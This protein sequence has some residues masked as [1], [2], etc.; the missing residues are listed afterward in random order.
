MTMIRFNQHLPLTDLFENLFGNTTR[1][2]MHSHEYD[3]EPLAN[4]L[5]KNN[6]FELQMA[7]PGVKKE[8]VKISLEKNVLSITSEKETEKADESVKYTRRE[9][10]YGTFCRSFT[11]PETVDVEKIK[12]DFR[13]GILIIELPKK[14]ETKVSREIKIG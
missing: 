6:G 11:L 7:I 3:C 1:E 12:A 9:F 2:P 4:I 5:E 14:E 13:D 8:D 10:V